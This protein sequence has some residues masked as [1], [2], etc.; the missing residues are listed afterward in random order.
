MH[1]MNDAE[2]LDALSAALRSPEPHRRMIAAFEL[3]KLADPAADELLWQA[4]TDKD[5]KVRG[6]AIQSLIRRDPRRPAPPLI[7]CLRQVDSDDPPTVEEII[8]FGLVGLESVDVVTPLIETLR[9]GDAELRVRAAHELAKTRDS[10][11]FEALLA[12]L[13][14]PDAPLREA[15][16]YALGR[17][18][19]AGVEPLVEI[20]RSSS[21][22]W[23]RE[24]ALATLAYFAPNEAAVDCVVQA[25]LSDRSPRLR[26]NVRQMLAFSTVGVAKKD[27]KPR[28]WAAIRRGPGRSRWRALR[29]FHVVR[30]HERHLRN[31]A[32]T[33]LWG[34][35]WRKQARVRARIYFMLTRDE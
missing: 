16:I 32:G 13:A 1:L 4:A 15:A 12:T 19:D 5:A 24:S 9:Q 22:T 30:R 27:P 25:A 23:E 6:T 2:S 11:A 29:A 33:G 28:L 35:L 10:R 31:T 20:V 21:N 14:E 3:S 26:A 34:S 7:R 17:Q 8:N 18:G